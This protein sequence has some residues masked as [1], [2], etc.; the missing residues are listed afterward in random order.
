MLCSHKLFLSTSIWT[1]NAVAI[2]NVC[3]TIY[4]RV[5]FLYFY[6]FWATSITSEVGLFADI[7][8]LRSSE[9]TSANVIIIKSADCVWRHAYV[10]NHSPTPS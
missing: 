7:L 5:Q 4:I 6:Q 2:L 8:E 3:P 9:L 10:H 1:G